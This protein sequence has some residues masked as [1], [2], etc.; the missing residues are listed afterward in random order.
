MFKKTLCH[1][2]SYYIGLMVG[3]K[4]DGDNV[5]LQGRVEAK[6]QNYFI[7][8]YQ[9]TVVLSMENESKCLEQKVLEYLLKTKQLPFSDE[10]VK[11]F[12]PLF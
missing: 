11:E 10:F 12:K 5:Y 9:R 4:E 7:K 6:L 2:R 3:L 1:F 8:H